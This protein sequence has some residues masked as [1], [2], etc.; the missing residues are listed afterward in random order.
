MIVSDFLGLPGKP[1][2]MAL[3]PDGTLYVAMWGGSGV[4]VVAPQGRLLEMIAVPAPHVSS[5]CFNPED[6]QKL[7]VTTS[8][9]RMGD[10]DLRRYPAAGQTV[11]LI[12]GDYER[13]H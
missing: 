1:D 11:E 13:A 12:I 5:L 7:Y 2:G 3:G 6:P 9:F 4:A 10:K 8:T